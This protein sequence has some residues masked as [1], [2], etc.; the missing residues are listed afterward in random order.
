MNGYERRQP[1]RAAAKYCGGRVPVLVLSRSPGCLPISS[2]A[3]ARPVDPLGPREPH[4]MPRARRVIFLFMPGGP[5]HVD[6]CDPKLRLARDNGKPSP[7]AYLGQTRKL[8]GSP[9]K[10]QQTR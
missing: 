5:S 2:A 9:W 8:L 7:K 4:L 6:T 1:G 10:F 3:A